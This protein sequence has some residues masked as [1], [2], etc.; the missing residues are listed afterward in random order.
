LGDVSETVNTGSE[1]REN[2]S[3]TS[4]LTYTL[5]SVTDGLGCIATPSGVS[6]TLLVNVEPEVSIDSDRPSHQ[7]CLGGTLTLDATVDAGSGTYVYRWLRGSTILAEGAASTYEIT[8]AQLSDAGS[9]SVILIAT[10]NGIPCESAPSSLN[11]TVTEATA[12][13]T[14]AASICFGT[15]ETYTATGGDLYEFNLLDASNAVVDTRVFDADDTYTTDLSLPIDLYT[16][17]VTVRDANG[18][19]DVFDLNIEV[20]ESPIN[21][22]TLSSSDICDG[23][24]ITASATAGYTNYDFIVNGLSVQSGSS[25]EY[26]S[27]TWNNGDVIKVA[28]ILGSCSVESAEETITVRDLPTIELSSDQTDD[29]AC[30][31]ETVVLTATGGVDYAFYVNTVLAQDFG[32]GST[33]SSVFN[34]GDVISVTGRAA[35]G[36][37]VSDDLTIQVNSPVAGLIAVDDEL[38]VGESLELTASGGTTYEFFSNGVSIGAASTDNELEILNPVDGDDFYVS[39]TDAYGCTAVSSTIEVTVHLLPV[40]TLTSDVTEICSGDPVA[41][42]AFGGNHYSFYVTRNSLDILQQES[43]SNQFTTTSLEAGDLV[44][45]VV[46]D[47]NSCSS[48]STSIPITVN[49]LPVAGINVL[50]S[51]NI[52]AGDD[53]TVEASGGVDYI[54]LINGVPHDGNASGWTTDVSLVI[55]GLV[56]GD[57]LSVIA[58]NASG[59][60][61]TSGEVTINVGAY[62][63]EFVLQPAYS[64]YCSGDPGVQLYLSGHESPFVL[65]ELYETSDLVNSVGTPSL[66]GG[67]IVWNNITEGD[68]QVKATRLGLLL[69]RWFPTIVEVREQPAP[70]VFN[71]TPTGVTNTC[72][73]NITLDGSE[74]GIDYNLL[75]NGV[76]FGG[77]VPGDGSPINMGSHSVGGIYTIEAVNASTGCSSMMNGQLDLDVVPNSGIFN[78]VSDPSSGIYCEGSGGVNLILEGSSNGAAYEVYRNNISTGITATGDGDVI[79]FGSFTQEGFY[80]V[81]IATQGG[82]IF[83]MDG[84]VEVSMDPAPD[85]FALE[86][87]NDGHFCVGDASGIEISQVG[88]QDGVVYQLWFDGAPVGAAII[89]AAND[90]LLP[91]PPFGTSFTQPGE[92]T[93][94]G[95]MPV[96]GCEGVV[97]TIML[98]EDPLPVVYDVTGDDSYCAGGQGVIGLSGSQNGVNYELVMDGVA[99]GSTL[100]GT[101]GLVEFPVSAE[102][103]YTITATISHLN[104]SCEVEM[105]GFVDVVE[106]PSPDK[107]VLINHVI[108]SNNCDI[109]ATITVLNS[110]AGV[111]YEIYWW[112]DED[113]NGPTGFTVNGDGTD[114][115]FQ[116]VE[117]V[118]NGEYK[119]LATLGDC[120]DFLDNGF[121]V[122]EPGLITKYAVLGDGAIC[123]GDGGIHIRLSSSE[124]G[125][126]YVLWSIG[127]G[128]GGVDVA[129]NTISPVIGGVELDFGLIEE[130]GDYIVLATNATCTDVA[131]HGMIELRFNPLPIAYQITGSGIFCDDVLGATI[132]LN[133]S[134]ID[135]VYTLVW[136][137][138]GIP[139]V[140]G[141]ADGDGDEIAFSTGVVDEGYYT[142]YARNELTGCTSSMNGTVVVTKMDLPDVSGISVNPAITYCDSEVGATVSLSSSEVDISYTIYEASDLTVAIA[143]VLGDGSVDLDFGSLIPE[144]TYTIM[145]TRS[146]GE[147]EV[148]V[149]EDIVISTIIA[150]EAFNVD[151]TESACEGEL[152][153]SVTNP[154]EGV[155]YYLYDDENAIRIEASLI[156]TGDVQWDEFISAN[157]AYQ[158]VFLRVVAVSENDCE[159][160]SDTGSFR[161]SVKELPNDFELFVEDSQATIA[162]DETL[163]VCSTDNFIIGVRA[164]QEG[165]LYRLFIDGETSR[166]ETIEGNDGDELL[167]NYNNWSAAT[168]SVIAF[169]QATGCSIDDYAFTVDLIENPHDNDNVN[170]AIEEENLVVT[171]PKEGIVYTLY[172]MVE[173][174]EP[175]VLESRTYPDVEATWSVSESGT[176]FVMA[177]LVGE[178]CPALESNLVTIGSVTPPVQPYSLF[179]SPILSYCSDEDG[180]AG[181][182]IFIDNTTVDVYYELVNLDDNTMPNQILKGN[183]G[184]VAFPDLVTGTYDYTITVE[185][186]NSDFSFNGENF[187]TI[188]E[189]KTPEKFTVNSGTGNQSVLLSSSETDAWYFL[190]RDGEYA[191]DHPN[192]GM[193]GTGSLLE[194][195]NV[196]TPGDYYVIA[197]GIAGSCEALMNGFVRIHPS[198]LKANPD[199]LYLDAEEL[200]GSID[201]SVL[202]TGRTSSDGNLVYSAQILNEALGGSL[203]VDAVNGLLTYYK[204]PSFFGKDSIHYTVSNPDIVD[205]R[206]TSYIIIMAGNKDFGNVQSFLLPN[207]FSPNGD[208]INERFVISGLGQT[209]E[210]SLEVFNR[211]G[212]IVFRSEGTRYD[213]DWDGTSN[214]GAMVSIGKELPNGVYFYVFEVKKNVEGTV[215][216]QRFSGYVELRR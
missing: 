98:T 12:G 89:G 137:D 35:N 202:V 145:A 117:L 80:R 165:V 37:E 60:V 55:S 143:S 32:N 141:T 33:Y 148:L 216:T 166:L 180:T 3:A 54:Y 29:V 115:A 75:L 85:T 93:V 151:Y 212:T 207:A 107:T 200:S 5:V 135:V 105:N 39:I 128:A 26:T 53:V 76:F 110:Q 71:M 30:L 78:L 70:A 11:V 191:F 58:R 95:T 213:N 121:I 142:V 201:L 52:G 91:L 90:P 203:T 63:A 194:F 59:C 169:S 20:R 206:S 44:Y 14:G 198:Q 113:N 175:A 56:D 7:V 178:T 208:G 130:A 118:G 185:G 101:G 114:K 119:I 195:P 179:G 99:T 74:S 188:T 97:G 192:F 187:F 96:S 48:N 100:P 66:V 159:R 62:P 2:F 156:E 51:N 104:T 147:C 172:R 215:E 46:R 112:V 139:R 45:V 186:D 28:I 18:C 49:D 72:P 210:S 158:D 36:C 38:C 42:E 184:Q 67:R 176:Y 102:A 64:E 13:L 209:E 163:T 189:Y 8:N 87:D 125:V 127:A 197:A 106:D 182:Q 108:S 94:I 133:D 9:Y 140:R 50:P 154:Q 190:I 124:A 84:V 82:C 22:L 73:V 79:D 122:N 193:I 41:F 136:D 111:E 17:R 174:Q 155:S 181:V 77:P 109:D 25:N 204:A 24:S 21:T 69:S 164:A 138:G 27:N 199:T 6:A 126:T 161:V 183:G 153:I 16:L 177:A 34:N 146:G 43:A 57:E 40:A 19:E 160:F 83:P 61:D 152:S 47:A 173:N 168:Y 196:E 170:L 92:Y 120:S 1:F 129:I 144:G 162:K 15:T 65:Y 123:E 88:Q 132:G 23:E 157:V 214:V 116:N 131:M 4:D 171:N 31:N 10:D 167:F 149:Q 211:W 103:R 68:Y 86:A 205:R 150:P 134:E 81:M